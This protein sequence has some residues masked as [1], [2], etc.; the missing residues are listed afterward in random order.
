MR[1]GKWARSGFKVNLQCFWNRVEQGSK[2]DEHKLN[3]TGV[4][5]SV[6]KWRLG[7]QT[8]NPRGTTD[9]SALQNLQTIAAVRI[10]GL[11]NLYTGHDQW[12]QNLPWGARK[13]RQTWSNNSF[14]REMAREYSIVREAIALE[15]SVSEPHSPRL[16][17]WRNGKVQSWVTC[18]HSSSH[19]VSL[20]NMFSFCPMLSTMGFGMALLCLDS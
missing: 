16:R 7:A 15:S 20:P 4:L 3:C 18:F 8:E 10:L 13:F 17:P 6:S 2:E 19:T 14:A 11:L 1:R 9:R 12:L 5:V